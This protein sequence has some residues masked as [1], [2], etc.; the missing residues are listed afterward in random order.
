MDA[1]PI[2]DN[3]HAN[4]FNN[5]RGLIILDLKRMYE[6]VWR[7][8]KETQIKSVGPTKGHEQGMVDLAETNGGL[9]TPSPPGIMT[10]LSWNGNPF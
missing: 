8:E 6:C 3:D 9:W 10:C 5:E 7:L 2:P 1:G 4:G